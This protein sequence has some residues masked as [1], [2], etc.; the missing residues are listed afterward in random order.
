MHAHQQ[1]I[2]DPDRSSSCGSTNEDRLDH[3]V[4]NEQIIDFDFFDI[5]RANMHAFHYK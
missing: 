3:A 2:G 4:A 1:A 5:Q